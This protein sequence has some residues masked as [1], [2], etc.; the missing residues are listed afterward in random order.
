MK[1][2]KEISRTVIGDI[3]TIKNHI[4]I[5]E[6]ITLKEINEI[7][8]EFDSDDFEERYFYG[9]LDDFNGDLYCIEIDKFLEAW[10]NYERLDEDDNPIL[11]KDNET[12]NKLNKYEGYDLYL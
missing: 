5:P 9:L 7:V 2:K 1:L 3:E 6:D 12:I 8:E 4:V 10:K 11:I